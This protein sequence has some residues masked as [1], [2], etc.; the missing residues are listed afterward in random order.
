MM[1]GSVATTPGVAANSSRSRPLVGQRGSALVTFVGR[2]LELLRGGVLDLVRTVR[3]VWSVVAFTLG[4]DH[5]DDVRPR[6][7]GV[8]A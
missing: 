2:D 1:S 6:R 8:R 7:V 5:V 4:V 3:R